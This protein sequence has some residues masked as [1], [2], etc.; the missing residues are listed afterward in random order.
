MDALIRDYNNFF[1]MTNLVLDCKSSATTQ[2]LA[3]DRSSIFWLDVGWGHNS[4]D[5][6][7]GF[8][9]WICFVTLGNQALW[10]LLFLS[11]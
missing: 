3:T 6:I 1:C 11:A 7:P 4:L 2:Q 8:S 10:F 5:S 9:S